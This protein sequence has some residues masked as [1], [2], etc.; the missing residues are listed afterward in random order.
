MV[1]LPGHLTV[2]SAL[3]YAGVHPASGKVVSLLGH[4]LD[5]KGSPPTFILNGRPGEPSDPLH[6]GDSLEYTDGVD[7][8]EPVT[9]EL[10]P[11]G[12]GNPQ[13]FLSAGPVRIKH[14]TVSGEVEPIAEAP[15]TGPPQMAL[16]FDDGPDPRSTP[17]IIDILN[18]AG[19]KAT[20]YV[21]GRFAQKFPDLIKSELAQGMLVENHTWNHPSLL[22]KPTAFVLDQLKR[23]KDTLTSLGAT[24]TSY[25]PPFGRQDP[26]VVAVG[27]GL[28]LKTVLWSVDPKDW[29]RP[30]VE[31][32]VKRVLNRTRAGSIILMHD[33]GGDRSQTV[34]ALP[35]ILAELKARGYT[36]ALLG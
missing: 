12:A 30:G 10:D 6:T 13:F 20:F 27:A 26:S 7:Q 21:Q 14:G 22:R 18:K 1:M 31:E 2:A 28:G 3:R 33:G 19:V 17:Q 9:E 25:R 34:A 11:H 15:T 5:A 24:V 29:T 36:L 32:I 4:L 16:S 23:T 8:T 35:I